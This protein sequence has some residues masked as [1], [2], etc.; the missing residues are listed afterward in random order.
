MQMRPQGAMLQPPG[1]ADAGATER[2]MGNVKQIVEQRGLNAPQGTSQASLQ[3]TVDATVD[4]LAR[5]WAL[6]RGRRLP[7]RQYI[8][9]LYGTIG[10]I[11]SAAEIVDE[12]VC[13]IV[14]Q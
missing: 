10:N 7:A 13:P 8:S 3:S 4:R 5:L 11:S 12:M 1:N 6:F 14:E 9:E 2:W